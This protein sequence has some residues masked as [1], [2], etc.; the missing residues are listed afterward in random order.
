[1]RGWKKT[2]AVFECFSEFYDTEEQYH[3]VVNGLWNRHSHNLNWMIARATDHDREH[4]GAIPFLDKLSW[5]V[6]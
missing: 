5:N 3:S 6:G 1:V 2:I 4:D